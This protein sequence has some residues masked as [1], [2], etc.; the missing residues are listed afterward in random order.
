MLRI[1]MTEDKSEQRW[2]LQGRLT[3]SFLQELIASWRANR[4]RRPTLNRVVDL[5]E[6]TCIDKDG[7]QVLL[8][9]IGDGARFVASGLYTKHLLESLSKS[10]ANSQIESKKA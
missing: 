6:V 9:M 7:E 8:M 2:V 3:A 4:D 5:D 10:S 1:T